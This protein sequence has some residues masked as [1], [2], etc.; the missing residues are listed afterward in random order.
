MPAKT[1]R[2]ARLLLAAALCAVAA[3]CQDPYLARRD[4]LTLGS[5]EA[6]Q[7]NI[8]KH[9]IDPWP[10]H[11]QQFDRD[12]SGERAQHAVE[13]YRNPS[14]GPGAASALP[15]VPVGPANAPPVSGSGFR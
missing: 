14:S 13:R 7:A 10:V 4:T 8:A 5:G 1:P 12:A 11:A 9:V 3:G 6:V 15:P 2:S